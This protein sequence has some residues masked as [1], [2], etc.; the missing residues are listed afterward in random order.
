MAERQIQLSLDWER[1]QTALS[2]LSSSNGFKLQHEF[3]TKGVS[4]S[5]S[6]LI[7]T[8]ESGQTWLLADF[9]NK[10]AYDIEEGN[11]AAGNQIVEVSERPSET[12]QTVTF[13]GSELIC[14]HLKRAQGTNQGIIDLLRRLNL[15]EINLERLKRSNLSEAG[16]SF[17]CVHQDL[18]TVHSMSREILTSPYE[19]LLNL[20]RGEVDNLKNRLPEFYEN[21]REIEDFEITGENPR[22]TYTNLL[23]DI[24]NFCDTA[25]RSL[26]DIGTYLS[27]RKMEQLETK[28]DATVDTAVDRLNAETNRAEEINNETEKQLA[29]KQEEVDQLILKVQNQLAEKPISQYKAIF[30]DQAKEYHKEAQ[31]W[32]WIAIGTTAAFFGA[33]Y[34]LPTLIESSGPGWTGILQNLFAKGF[35]LS[36][37]YLWLN[38]SIK[39]YAAQKH[40]EVINTHRQNALETFDTFVAAAEGNRETRDAVLLSATDAIFDANQTGYLSTKGSSSDSRSPIQQIIREIISDK[41]PPKS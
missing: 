15:D 25:K 18:L 31:N 2:Q 14:D 35:L 38:R 5:Q 37:I 1:F 12:E 20:S 4:L 19:W 27:S 30:A 21:V 3:K 34:L 32:L 6:L 36:P 7:W 17:E 26:R 13:E 33:F 29:E 11:D 8:G 40:L 23:Q 41:S 39:N 10:K 24:S 9:K 16:F 22:E 28:V